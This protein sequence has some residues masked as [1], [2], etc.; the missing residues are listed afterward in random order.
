MRHTCKFG[1]R[2]NRPHGRQNPTSPMLEP[3]LLFPLRS[4]TTTANAVNIK[5]YCNSRGRILCLARRM[6]F[7][8][9]K[10]KRAA[11][12]LFCNEANTSNNPSPRN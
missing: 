7:H 5:P 4:M 11:G 3:I 12:A 1:P 9:K 10:I 6:G 2:L 8:P